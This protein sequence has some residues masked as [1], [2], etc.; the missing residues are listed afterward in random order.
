MS[1]SVVV[2]ANKSCII[3]DG[4]NSNNNDTPLFPTSLLDDL[5][6]TGSGVKF[7]PVLSVSSPGEGLL[8]RSLSLEDYDRG[9]LELLGQL[10]SVDE[11][12][13]DQWEQRWRE[14]KECSGTY[15]VIVIED[16]ENKRV[17]GAA[18]MVMEKKFIHSCGSVGRLEDVVVSDQYRGRQ[19]GKLVVS[20]ATQLAVKL[21]AYKVTLNCNDKMI[22]FYSSIGYKSED[23]NSNYM[24]IR[25]Q[26]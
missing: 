3:I 16:L 12:S 5:D 25:V 17:I 22:K 1:A 21:G 9:F 4:K 7:D 8:V 24:C 15:Y 10:T 6:I 20:V 2:N 23:G 14:M 11:I 26:H 13:R 19:L 18:T